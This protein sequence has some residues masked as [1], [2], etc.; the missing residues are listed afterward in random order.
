SAAGPVRLLDATLR[1]LPDIV[2]DTR[3]ATEVLFPGS[4]VALVE[5]VYKNSPI[6]DWFN[7]ALGMTIAAYVGERDRREPACAIRLFERGAGTGVATEAVVRHLAP[8]RPH[9]EEYCYTDISQRFLSYGE[10]RYRASAPYL[11]FRRFDVEREPSEQGFAMGEYDVV[12][13]SNVLHAT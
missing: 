9:V 7:D 11:R 3:D 6:A 12:I 8:Y 13:A 4:S 10:E 2:V 1:A 5:G